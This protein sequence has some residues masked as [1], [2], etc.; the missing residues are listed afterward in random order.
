MRDLR[1][2]DNLFMLKNHITFSLNGPHDARLANL[3]LSPIKGKSRN[4]PIPETFRSRAVAGCVCVCMCVAGCSSFGN[5]SGVMDRALQAFGLQSPDSVRA[6]AAITAPDARFAESMSAPSTITL[7]LHAGD[8]VNTDAAGRSLSVIARIY[9]LRGKDTFASAP[10][11]QFAE[12]RST[13]TTDFSSD[14]VDVKEIILIPGQQ[15]DVVESFK[16]ETPFFAIVALFRTHDARR[17]RFIFD[18]KAAA[19]TG[20]TIGLHACALSVSTGQPIGVPEEAL[21]VAGVRCPH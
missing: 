14:V 9:K 7:R 4:K 1:C 20:I 8:I 18:A 13:E 19:S 12:L 5:G 16:A 21:G 3:F 2:G 6:T 17:W 15:H 10:Y 11:S